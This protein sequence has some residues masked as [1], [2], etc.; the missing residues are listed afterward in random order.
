MTK[1]RRSIESLRRANP[2]YWLAI[3]VVERDPNDRPTGGILLAK[4]REP[5]ALH[6]IV[7]GLPTNPLR[8]EPPRAR[9]PSEGDLYETFAGRL[10]DRMVRL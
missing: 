10:R 6:R 7:E 2:G 1:A 3:R 5:A 9:A 4:A 8:E